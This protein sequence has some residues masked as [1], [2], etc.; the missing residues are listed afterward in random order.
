MAEIKHTRLAALQRRC[1]DAHPDR[2][3]L[4]AFDGLE[5]LLQQAKIKVE[6]I[7]VV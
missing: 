1:V 7:G 4:G 5:R 3:A 2:D 6:K